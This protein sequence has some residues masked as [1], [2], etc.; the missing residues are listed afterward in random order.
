MHWGYKEDGYG[1]KDDYQAQSSSK[2][3]VRAHKKSL[4]G[5]DWKSPAKIEQNFV[6]M[7]NIEHKR[8]H[9]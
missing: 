5:D 1:T 9:V 7:T 8:P 4:L 6:M 2:F 3:S